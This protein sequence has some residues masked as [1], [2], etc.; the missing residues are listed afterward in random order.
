MEGFP[1]ADLIKF[2]PLILPATGM[3]KNPG[4]ATM[5]GMLGGAMGQGVG[6][7]GPLGGMLGGLGGQKPGGMPYFGGLRVPGMSG[8]TGAQYPTGQYGT[9]EEWLKMF[10]GRLG[11]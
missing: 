9:P 1:I 4:M 3:V 2:L 8:P 7:K 11:G 6:G 10:G 5:L